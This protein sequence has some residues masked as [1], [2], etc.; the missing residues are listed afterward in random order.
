[1]TTEHYQFTLIEP[2][3]VSEISLSNPS[4]KVTTANG[5]INTL[6]TQQI[7]DAYEG[8]LL[9]I[10]EKVMLKLGSC[11]LSGCD[12]ITFN[13]DDADRVSLT[14]TNN[15]HANYL[16]C[17]AQAMAN[18]IAGR[19]PENGYANIDDVAAY[20]TIAGII[21]GHNSNETALKPTK[22]VLTVVPSVYALDKLTSEA[23]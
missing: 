1:M 10:D 4:T 2:D 19:E 20:N 8:R 11:S 13:V 23:A 7:V 5:N 9:I 17:Y 18:I 22:P 6:S 16:G 3:V 21:S 15:P 12:V 14:G